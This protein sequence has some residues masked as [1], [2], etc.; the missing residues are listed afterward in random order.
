ML[1]AADVA[2]GQKFEDGVARFPEMFDSHHPTS[3]EWVFIR[4]THIP[5]DGNY[6]S[7]VI[8]EEHIGQ[9]CNAQMHPFGVPSGIPARSNP[10]DYCDI[11]YRAIVPKLVDNLL[12]AGRCCS[13]EF[14][15]Q[16]AMRII[17]PAMG[18]GQAAGLAA[19]VAIDRNVLP[20]DID[21]KQIRQMLIEEGVELD[22]PTDGYW[23]ELRNT[24]GRFVINGG[25]AISLL[26]K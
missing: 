20:R 10:K 26:P 25:D 2:K 23:E 16:G 4:H 11:P 24:D 22:K 7:A 19:C 13:A 6:G 9:N 3:P 15:A 8:E 21:G 17:G 12:C 14:H 5:A 1:K 18:T